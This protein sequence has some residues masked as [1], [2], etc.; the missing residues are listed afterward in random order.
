MN[1][2]PQYV[3]IQNYILDLIEKGKLKP[4][5]KIP[6]EKEL[7]SMFGVSRITTSTAIKQL[8]QKGYLYR[9]KGKGTFVKDNHIEQS[10]K[11]GLACSF[12]FENIFNEKIESNNKMYSSHIIKAS[13]DAARFLNI[14]LGEQINAVTRI[15]YISDIPVACEFSYIPISIIEKVESNSISNDITISQ[16]IRNEKGI[17]FTRNKIYINTMTSGVFESDLLNIDIGVL[18]VL[19]EHVLYDANDIPLSYGR[20]IFHDNKNYKISLDFSKL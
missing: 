17:N 2:V 1:D 7:I 10:R 15:K 11:D 18:L 13:K 3:K 5:D 6:T 8:A 20:I 16:Y 4:D 9:M 14:D 19:I 12:E